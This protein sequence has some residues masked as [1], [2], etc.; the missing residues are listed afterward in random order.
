MPLSP[1]VQCP[2]EGGPADVRAVVVDGELGPAGTRLMDSQLRGFRLH[3]PR[4]G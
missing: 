3:E 1:L 2:N 4:F